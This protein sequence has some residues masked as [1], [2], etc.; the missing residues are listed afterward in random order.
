[1]AHQSVSHIII[2]ETDD[3]GELFVEML[4]IPSNYMGL[5]DPGSLTYYN[6]RDSKM[7]GASYFSTGTTMPRSRTRWQARKT[8]RVGSAASRSEAWTTPGPERCWSW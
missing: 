3:S 7:G 2:C 8:A 1:M 5:D 6:M 4:L